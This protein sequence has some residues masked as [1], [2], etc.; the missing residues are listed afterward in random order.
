MKCTCK[1][2][3]VELTWKNLINLLARL[4]F[5]IFL[6]K[7][8]YIQIPYSSTTGHVKKKKKRKKNTDNK[9]CTL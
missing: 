3:Q 7:Y 2:N 5:Y 1:D 4:N 6:A 8:Q 9:P